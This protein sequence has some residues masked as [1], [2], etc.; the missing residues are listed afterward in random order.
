MT[1]ELTIPALDHGQI[2]VF[3]MAPPAPQ[4]L[5]D[6]TPAALARVLGAGTL[7]TDFIDI[8]ETAS[9]GE[10][11]LQDYLRSGYDLA[12]DVVDDAALGR[13]NGVV[14]LMMSRATGP[15]ATTL[16]LADG[17]SHVTTLGEKA[18]ISVNEPLKS[19]ASQGVIADPPGKK[20]VSDAAMSGRIAMIALVVLF[21]LVGVMIWVAG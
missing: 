4:D 2:R 16:T 20:P 15:K 14:I 13:L 17:V 21:A 18:S 19:E 7:N 6:K 5:L 11:S 9:L 10:M 8:F 3:Q 12:A 1:T